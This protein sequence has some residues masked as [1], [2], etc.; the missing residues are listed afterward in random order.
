M[1]KFCL[2]WN[3]FQQNACSAFNQLRKDK[4]LTDVT[5]VSEE[6]EHILAHKIVLS[7]SSYFFKDL[8]KKANH[9]NPLIFLS[10]FDSKV[11][12]T[13]LDYIYNGAVNLYQEEIDLFLESAQ[14]LK[15]HGLTQKLTEENN[16]SLFV[17]NEVEKNNIT[18]RSNLKRDEVNLN[19]TILQETTL[20]E[21][22]T[23]V[24]TIDS[25]NVTQDSNY[26]NLFENC[27]DEWK[28]KNCGKTTKTKSNMA[29][30]V[31][32]HIEGLSFQCNSCTMVFRNRMQLHTHTKRKHKFFPIY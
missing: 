31:E 9:T 28:C 25:S 2:N 22:E 30:H 12:T 26:D 6:G 15:I 10:G 21:K 8:F 7:S 18:G 4:E 13:V 27:G 14:K 29:L 11:L 32:I 16:E 1:E 5:L 20:Y 3:D 23:K 17:D 19:T 24:A